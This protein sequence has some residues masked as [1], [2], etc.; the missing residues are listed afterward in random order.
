MPSGVFWLWEVANYDYIKWQYVNGLYFNCKNGDYVQIAHE[1][2]M[3]EIVYVEHVH[4]P[5]INC[6][7]HGYIT[8]VT[9]CLLFMTILQLMGK[10]VTWIIYN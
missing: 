10:L 7:C 1:W 2:S 8:F 4:N 6:W 3:D 5:W 9:T